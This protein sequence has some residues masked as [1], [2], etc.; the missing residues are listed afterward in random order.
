MTYSTIR[1]ERTREGIARLTL[2]RPEKHNA[3][4]S[5]MIAEIAAGARELGS[6]AGVRVVVL[7]AE[8][9]SFCAGGDLEWM[10]AQFKSTRERRLGEARA[11]AHMLRA[12]NEMPKPVIAAVHGAAYGGGVGLISVADN[13]I[14]ASTA[15]FGLTETRLGLIPATIGPYVTQRLGEGATRRVFMSARIFGAEEAQ[16]LG[17][18]GSVV[19]PAELPAAVEAEA[20]AYLAAAPGA[21]AAAKALVGRLTNRIDEA[22]I[23][24]TIRRLA[25][26]W[27]GPEA[28]EGIS[29]FFEKRRPDWVGD[30]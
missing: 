6:D 8:G 16:R 24:D 1:I 30:R 5:P 14:A 7:A 22:V 26:T 13:A 29:A 27:E 12:V 11:L 23:E 10:R 2:A 4:N 17:L 19:A 3:L 9:E 20:R 25:D 28:H 15:K 18:V 21:V